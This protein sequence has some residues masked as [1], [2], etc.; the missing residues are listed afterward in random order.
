MFEDDRLNRV[1]RRLDPAERAVVFAYAEGEGTTWTEAAA[2]GATDPAALGERVR[3]K[4]K[5]IAAGQARRL[6]MTPSAVPRP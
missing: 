5:R 3:R 1:L 2:G 6:A 4:A